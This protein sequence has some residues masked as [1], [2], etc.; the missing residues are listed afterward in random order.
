LGV[1]A[2]ASEAVLSAAS[3]ID[4]RR[5][6]LVA[7]LTS[8]GLPSLA[9]ILALLLGL[10]LLVLTPRLW[11]GT[12]TAVSLAIA[13]LLLL[14]M[15]NIVKGLAYEE[16]IPEACLA[17]LL[18][19]ARAPSRSVAGTDLVSL[20]SVL[21]QRRGRWRIAPCSRRLWCPVGEGIRWTRICTTRSRMC[22][23]HRWPIRT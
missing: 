7:D 12:R 11:R 14:A 6:R 10:A 4:P 22:S 8:P 21:R 17:L 5:Q 3:P 15:L 9:H 18:I 2:I 16:S 20:R 23:P 13:G 19:A 1:A